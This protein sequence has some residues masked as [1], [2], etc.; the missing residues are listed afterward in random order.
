ME[1]SMLIITIDLV[2]GGYEFYCETIGSMRIAN[3]SNL[4]DTCD[5]SVEVTEAANDLTATRLG[6]ASAS[7]SRMTAVRACG[8]LWRGLARRPSRRTSTISN[9]AAQVGEMAAS[10]KSDKRNLLQVGSGS[11]P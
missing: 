3:L 7:S 9:L 10:S 5:Y 8:P 2:P 4:G 1:R 11:K 6:T